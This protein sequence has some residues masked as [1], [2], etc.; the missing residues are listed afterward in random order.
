MRSAR[1]SRW[2]L[3]SS[4]QVPQARGAVWWFPLAAI[5]GVHVGLLPTL[6]VNNDGRLIQL[7]HPR[8]PIARS[9]ETVAGGVNERVRRQWDARLG[10]EDRCAV[11]LR[12]EKNGIDR[13]V[14]ARVELHHEARSLARHW[15]GDLPGG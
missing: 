5:E 14:P 8:I 15:L 4:S 9:C 2:R 7:D 13:S 1:S 10:L 6:L 11:D 12:P 3:A